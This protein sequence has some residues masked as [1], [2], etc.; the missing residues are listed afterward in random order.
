MGIAVGVSRTA[1]ADSRPSSMVPRPSSSASARTSTR[2]L[3]RRTALPG[4]ALLF[5][6]VGYVSMLSLGADTTRAHGTAP[7]ALIVPVFAGIV[8]VTRTAGGSIP[9]RLGGRL[10][11]CSSAA[12]AAAGLL[13]FAVATSAPAELA[14][15]LMVAVGQSMAVPALGL[16][17]LATVSRRDQ[18]AAAGLFFAWFDAGV[19][20]GGPAVGLAA[21]VGGPT[22]GM[23]AASA[24]VAAVIVIAGVAGRSRAP[25]ICP[26]VEMR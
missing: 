6:N 4:L 12:V 17:A 18:G 23:E 15:L 5:V 8:L 24:A 20:L 3:L 10:T 19:G 1:R 9:D 21:S 11:A 25:A 7:P 14:G 13:I 16:L 2:D 22:G 26:A